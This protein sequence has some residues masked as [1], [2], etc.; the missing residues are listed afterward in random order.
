MV[1]VSQPDRG[2]RSV[3][4][5]LNQIDT[6]DLCTERGSGR[7]HFDGDGHPSWW[8][9]LAAWLNQRIGSATVSPLRGHATAGQSGVEPLSLAFDDPYRRSDHSV[10][11]VFLPIGVVHGVDGW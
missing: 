5:G 4:D 6:A 7:D 11:A 9:R 2:E 3:V 10:D 8:S 1:V